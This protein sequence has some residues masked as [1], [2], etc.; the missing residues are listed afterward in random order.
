MALLKAGM[1]KMHAQGRG[2]LWFVRAMVVRIARFPVSNHCVASS[3]R[4]WY[5][6]GSE[7]MLPT[8]NVWSRGQDLNLRPSGYEPDELPD[9]STPQYLRRVKRKKELYAAF[10]CP[11]RMWRNLHNWIQS[12]LRRGLGRGPGEDPD[13]TLESAGRH[14]EEDLGAIP[15]GSARHSAALRGLP[16]QRTELALGQ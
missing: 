8:L 14:S 12:R 5:E 16:Q 7:A 11:S 2:G 3:E 6:K 9:C 4:L 15:A 10:P 13:A 1:H